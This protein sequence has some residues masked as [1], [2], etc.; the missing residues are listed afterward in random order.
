[1]TVARCPRPDLVRPARPW[2]PVARGLA[3]LGLL[4]RPLAAQVTTTPPPA[5]AVTAPSAAAQS[6]P[7]QSTLPA[8]LTDAEFWRMVT[9]FSEPSGYFQSDNL[10]GNEL[11]LQEVIPELKRTT[12]P[13]G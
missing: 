6:A 13:N 8:Q 7:A 1:M 12:S 3:P 10:V 5:P 4:A 2:L 9:E 11:T